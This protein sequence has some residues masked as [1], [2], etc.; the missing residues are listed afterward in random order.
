MFHPLRIGH[1][2]LLHFVIKSISNKNDGHTPRNRGSINISNSSMQSRGE[3][4]S[5][6]TA[7]RKHKLEKLL[8]PPAD[9]HLVLYLWELE[10]TWCPTCG[11]A[12]CPTCPCCS[13]LVLIVI[14]MSTAWVFC[15]YEA[16]I[17]VDPASLFKTDATIPRQSWKGITN[18]FRWWQWN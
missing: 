3:L 1:S 4:T 15:I 12:H 17:W 6:A 10:H 14:K 7:R 9:H 2:T 8:S 18:I 11:N 16:R 5:V 13:C